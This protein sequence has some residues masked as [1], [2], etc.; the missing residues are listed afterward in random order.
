[1]YNKQSKCFQTKSRRLCC[2][3]YDCIEAVKQVY[4][5]LEECGLVSGG[6]KDVARVDTTLQS[7]GCVCVHV[8]IRSCITVTGVVMELNILSLLCVYSVTLES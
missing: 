8:I 5:E 1:M 2:V 4:S 3:V 6:C 7:F